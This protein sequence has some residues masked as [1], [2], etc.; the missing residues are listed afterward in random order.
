MGVLKKQ[1]ENPFAG[2][3]YVFLYTEKS[4]AGLQAPNFD[5]LLVHWFRN[6]IRNGRGSERSFKF[7]FYMFG[8]FLCYSKHTLYCNFKI[9]TKTPMF[10]EK[11]C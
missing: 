4:V 7:S 9:A 8:P 11:L 6:G 5:F 3:F 2:I 10:K 1:I